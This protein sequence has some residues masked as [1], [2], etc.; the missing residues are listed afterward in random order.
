MTVFVAAYS[1]GLNALDACVDRVLVRAGGPAGTATFSRQTHL[2]LARVDLGYRLSPSLVDG[3][4]GC[5]EL[6]GAL[7]HR[8]RKRAR[9]VQAGATAGRSSRSGLL[10]KI[11]QGASPFAC[12]QKLS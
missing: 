4:A 2:C 11:G 10:I 9:H 7:N 3:A 12:N 6:A 8:S 5:T 1:I